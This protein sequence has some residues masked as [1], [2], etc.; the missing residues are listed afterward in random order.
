MR[1]SGPLLPIG[2]NRERYQA[3]IFGLTEIIQARDEISFWGATTPKHHFWSKGY[4]V[5][6]SPGTINAY[7]PA[8]TNKIDIGPAG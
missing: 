6:P 3:A 5:A 8:K 7:W 2:R 1:K 4:E